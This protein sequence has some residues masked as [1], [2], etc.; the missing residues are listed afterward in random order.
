MSLSLAVLPTTHRPQ[1]ED[2][3]QKLHEAEEIGSR[4]ASRV[5]LSVLWLLKT[6]TRDGA[7]R[8]PKAVRSREMHPFKHVSS[9]S[10]HLRQHL[11]HV[12][13]H[14]CS[15]SPLPLPVASTVPNHHHVA[16]TVDIVRPRHECRRPPNEADDARRSSRARGEE[17]RQ[18]PETATQ[19]RNQ[20]ADR[21]ESYHQGTVGSIRPLSPAV[22]DSWNIKRVARR[23]KQDGDT[24]CNVRMG[25]DGTGVL[26]QFRDASSGT[27][28][29]ST[30][31]AYPHFPCIVG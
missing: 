4:S 23:I 17:H 15:S 21:V 8:V 5:C 1:E 29:A 20:I 27:K 12:R 2:R 31:C 3:L 6:A 18:V 10:L 11:Q 25:S 28:R 24:D 16:R 26:R 22:F 30:R 9:E 13:R 14:E 19:F 7:N